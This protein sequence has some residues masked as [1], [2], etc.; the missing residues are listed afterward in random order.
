MYIMHDD[1]EMVY[2][3]NLSPVVASSLN[4]VELSMG[5]Y[6]EKCNCTNKTYS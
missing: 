6:K 1:C 2:S 4:S 5:I 3:Y